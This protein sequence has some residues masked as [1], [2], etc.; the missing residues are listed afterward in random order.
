MQDGLW[1]SGLLISGTGLPKGAFPVW[2]SLAVYSIASDV[3]RNPSNPLCNTDE[4]D[5][6]AIYQAILG[7]ILSVGLYSPQ[8]AEAAWIALRLPMAHRRPGPGMSGAVCPDQGS[9]L[10]GKLEAL[11]YRNQT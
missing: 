7:R 10:N 9:T 1:G 2:C 3:T 5:R 6:T 4:E 8:W 11:Q